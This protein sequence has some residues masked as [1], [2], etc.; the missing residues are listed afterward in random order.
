MSSPY[1]ISPY[2]N[3]PP[4][5]QA[6]SGLPSQTEGVPSAPPGPA[7]STPPASHPLLGPS[8]GPGMQ[9]QPVYPPPYPTTIPAA[10]NPSNYPTPVYNGAPTQNRN[11]PGVPYPPPVGTS[12]YHPPPGGPPAAV[13]AP[14]GGPPSPYPTPGS[15][16][17]PYL[18]SQ[19]GALLYPNVD[20]VAGGGP[21]TYPPTPQV[22]GARQ[23]NPT[24][25]TGATEY[26]QRPQTVPH[27]GRYVGSQPTYVQPPIPTGMLGCPMTTLS[28]SVQ[29]KFVLSS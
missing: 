14:F 21:H 27:A 11:Y 4:T 22:P 5:G 19:P 13:P 20:G 24:T 10:P 12:P 18:A 28:Y 7:V 6:G 23:D 9:S 1:P 16:P 29:P 26:G 17:P 25:G 15:G 8:A 2:G 3:Y